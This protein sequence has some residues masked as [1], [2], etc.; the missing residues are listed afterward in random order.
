MHSHKFSHRD[1]RDLDGA[2]A[3]K[4][5]MLGVLALSAAGAV[6]VAEPALSAGPV[7]SPSAGA[8]PP[9]A[10]PVAPGAVSPGAGTPTV[11][12]PQVPLGASALPTTTAPHGFPKDG[13]VPTAINPVPGLDVVVRKKPGGSVMNLQTDGNGG[14]TLG[15]VTPGEYVIELPVD[16]LRS[17]VN[18]LDAKQLPGG[19]GTSGAP[20]AG[21]A[22][23]LP[24]IQKQREADRIRVN[25][26]NVPNGLVGHTFTGTTTGGTPHIQFTVTTVAVGTDTTPTT[27]GLSLNP[28]SVVGG[29]SSSYVSRIDWG[30]GSP[31]MI[32]DR[33][34]NLIFH[35]PNAPGGNTTVAPN[36]PGGGTTGPGHNGSFFFMVFAQAK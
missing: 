23:S 24:A 19:T 18:R 14:F 10:S 22:P 3:R 30:D 25:F 26:S 13:G 29:T 11:G 12:A 20:S 35:L 5:L 9:K 7:L 2:H 32:F 28:T 34:G 36:N 16:S 1:P 15:G 21:G 31:S 4:W 8:P 6:V 17:A 33:W 27:A